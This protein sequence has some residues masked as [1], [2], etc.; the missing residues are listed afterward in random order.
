MKKTAAV[1]EIKKVFAMYGAQTP[2]DKQLLRALKK[3]KLYE[4]YVLA[5]VVEDLAGRGFKIAFH[6]RN[7]A[8]KG[9]HGKIKASDPHFVV[10]KPGSLKVDFRIF[11]D[12]E[13]ETLGRHTGAPADRSSRHEL[14]IVVVRD[15]VMS[16]YPK[17]SD[18]VFGAECKAVAN[19]EKSLVKEALGVRRE[20]SLL[21]KDK[22]SE[23][24]VA[25]GLPI[26]EV[27]ANPA[28]EFWFAFLDP[29]GDLYAHSPSAF[30]IQFKYFPV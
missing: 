17:H 4:L 25:G 3:G 1:A 18:L 27:N 9:A 19:V 2:G 5:R 16:G 6:G 24:T 7:L 30:G 26:V 8:F 29:D 15:S 13:F 11:V 12:I 21:V 20:L 28:S 14:D 23:L 22:L 10:S